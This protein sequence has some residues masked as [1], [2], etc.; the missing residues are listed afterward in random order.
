MGVPAW[1]LIIGHV[2]DIAW[3]DKRIDEAGVRRWVEITGEVSEMEKSTLLAASDVLLV[4]SL[5][6][7]FSFVVLEALAHQCMAIL[8]DEYP[9]SDYLEELGAILVDRA[10]GLPAI[11]SAVLRTRDGKRFRPKPLRSWRMFADDIEAALSD[12]MRG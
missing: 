5:F 11:A 9:S 7:A 6:E 8:F 10:E 4:L 1:L 12:V 3:L 2:D